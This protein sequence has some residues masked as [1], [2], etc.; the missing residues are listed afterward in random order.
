[1]CVYVHDGNLQSRYLTSISLWVKDSFPSQKN[2]M[3][4][5][6]LFPVKD[7]TSHIEN[8]MDVFKANETLEAHLLFQAIL[9]HSI[10]HYLYNNKCHFSNICLGYN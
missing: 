2:D 1:M 8:A 6:T 10:R 9:L 3:L 5:M 7:V 4:Q